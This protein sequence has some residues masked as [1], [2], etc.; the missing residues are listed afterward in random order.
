[1]E[2]DDMNVLCL[3]A[4]IIGI[5]LAREVTRAFAAARFSR[6]ERHVRRLV[7]VEEIERRLRERR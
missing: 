1:V 4:R 5:E 6:E 7:K 3:G 2:H